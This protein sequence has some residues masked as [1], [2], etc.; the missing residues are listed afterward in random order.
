MPQL[1]FA[2]KFALMVTAALTL[3][4]IEQSSHA[5]PYAYFVGMSADG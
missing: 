5:G 2:A 3:V 4:S 1:P